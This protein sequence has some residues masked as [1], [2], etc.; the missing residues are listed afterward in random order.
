MITENAV[1]SLPVPAVVGIAMIGSIGPGT[2]CAPSY[3]VMEPPYL[4]R[5]PTAFATSIGLPPPSATIL[6][7]PDSLYTFVAASTISTVGFGRISRKLQ[8]SIP[9]DSTIS[10]TCFTIPSLS[11]PRSETI[12]IFLEPLFSSNSGN[13][14]KEPIP[15]IMSC[16][17]L[18]I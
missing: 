3:S 2:R 7:A 4:A 5:T 9:S 10:V 18:N 14:F 16:G 13:L 17:T 8:V 15:N 11:N 1:T 6:V 12:I